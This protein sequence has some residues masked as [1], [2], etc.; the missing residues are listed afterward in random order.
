MLP[1]TKSLS[2]NEQQLHAVQSPPDMPLLLLAGAGTGKTLTLC[3]RIAH[4]ISSGVT[5]SGHILAVTFT[6]KA[7]EELCERVN[8]IVGEGIAQSLTVKVGFCVCI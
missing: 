1:C 8:A 7:A 2:L 4:L 6:N 5:S 3:H